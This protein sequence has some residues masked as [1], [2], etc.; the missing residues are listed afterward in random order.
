M[1]LAQTQNINVGAD[2]RSLVLHHVLKSLNTSN[3]TAGATSAME[4]LDPRH[5]FDQ[6]AN[7]AEKP[8]T[9]ISE[10][11]WAA[12]DAVTQANKKTA[13]P[14]AVLLR[15]VLL[16]DPHKMREV[17]QALSQGSALAALPNIS[18]RATD[19]I[20]RI[21]NSDHKLKTFGEVAPSSL[22]R[23]LSDLSPS[24]IYQINQLL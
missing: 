1:P 12:G 24:I 14:L 10:K 18:V 4:A 2:P 5:L 20:S 21:A 23:S 6:L 15:L 16:N 13:I 22:L 9:H 8:D 17:S 7:I 11:I 3:A 19:A